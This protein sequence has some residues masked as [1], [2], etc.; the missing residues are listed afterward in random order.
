MENIVGKRAI[1]CHEQVPQFLAVFQTVECRDVEKY[2]S[3]V[4][5]FTDDLSLIYCR[6]ALWGPGSLY[7]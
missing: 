3:T 7:E 4:M 2:I 6:A 1:A 5:S